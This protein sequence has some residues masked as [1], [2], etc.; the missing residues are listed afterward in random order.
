MGG[1]NTECQF[2]KLS[3]VLIGSI[4]A[5]A[6]F[7]RTPNGLHINID[8]VILFRYANNPLIVRFF[9][10][11]VWRCA[12]VRMNAAHRAESKESTLL[13]KSYINA[14]RAE[15]SPTRR[16]RLLLLNKTFHQIAFSCKTGEPRTDAVRA[17]PTDSILC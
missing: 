10:N 4:D 1:K 15:V 11:E 12:F 3:F 8:R 17:R 9:F 16:S 6:I 7:I 13:L 2:L 14:L 5:L